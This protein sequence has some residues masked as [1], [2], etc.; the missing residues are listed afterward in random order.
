MRAASVIAAFVVLLLIVL[1]L[2]YGMYSRSG[3]PLTP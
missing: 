2:F 1:W 3:F